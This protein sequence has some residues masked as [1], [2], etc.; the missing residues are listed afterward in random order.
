MSKKKKL[1]AEFRKNRSARAR[2]VDPTREFRS[3]DQQAED[4]ALH[5]RISG[6]GELSR[7]RVVVGEVSDEAGGFSVVPDVDLAVCRRGR[8]LAVYGLTSD[9][10][11][12]D[13]SIF[14]CAT[15]RLLKTLAT[16]QRHVVAAGDWVYFRPAGPS[17]GIIERIEP[18]RG[19]IS[20]TSRGRQHIIAVNVDQLV[21]VSSAAE[22]YLKPNLIDRFLI[23]AEQ[24]GLSPLVCINKVDL[25]DPAQ[26]QPLVGVYSR[27][28]YPVVL[29]SARQGAGIDR[30]RRELKGR[31][32]VVAGQSGVG[33][34][35]ILNAVEEGLNLRIGDVSQETQKGKHT[36]TTARLIRLAMGGYVVDTPGIRQFQL[37]DV[38][39]AE[40]VNYFRDLRPYVSRCHFPDCTH[41]HEAH[42][43]V[44]DAVADGHLDARRYESYLALLDE[45]P[46]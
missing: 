34:S 24:N 32:S 46:A 7:K 30:V 23:T 33:K 2:G 43:A 44:K 21:I 9:V 13:G 26:L 6:K 29:L 25:V 3:G 18:R 5:E 37:W 36:T 42:C 27:M 45:Q 10:E 39:P 15:R 28:G 16:D 41:S 14:Q 4:R 1:R 12:D 31:S 38:I 20:R 22:P 19:V 35:S 40:V 17:E 8:V 11:A